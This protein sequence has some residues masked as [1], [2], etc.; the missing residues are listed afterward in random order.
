MVF[1]RIINVVTND[2]V[3]NVFRSEKYVEVE[4]L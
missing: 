4:L 2:E 3:K 1:V